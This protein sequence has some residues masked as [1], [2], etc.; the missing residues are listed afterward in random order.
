M[1]LSPETD[2]DDMGCVGTINNQS[3]IHNTILQTNIRNLRIKYPKAIIVYAD[4]WNAYRYV[5]KNAPRLGFRELYKV[6]CGHIGEPY[7]FD[8]AAT[9]G[10]RA[11]SS[12][13]NPSQYINWD[14]VH[15][16][17]A[18]YKVVFDMF[19]NGPYT[20]PPFKYLLRSKQNS[21]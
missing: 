3:Y 16:T 17:E 1:Y 18:M 11:A 12:C 13:Q 21:G 4:Y 20:R 8:V 7:N 15:L 5:I 6:C 2:R 9:C 14:G 10:S 19:L